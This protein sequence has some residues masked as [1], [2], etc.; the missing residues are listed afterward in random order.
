MQ[1]AGALDPN[2]SGRLPPYPEDK[3]DLSRRLSFGGCMSRVLELPHERDDVGRVAD[4][5]DV[6]VDEVFRV[7]LEYPS[8][9]WRDVLE[10]S[11]QR[12]DVYKVCTSQ[13]GIGQYT[14]DN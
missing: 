4:V 5:G 3:V 12:D 10:Q 13:D 7:I 8:N 11:F 6:L 2:V 1:S 9:R 14:C